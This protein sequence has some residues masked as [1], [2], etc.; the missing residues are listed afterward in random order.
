MCKADKIQVGVDPDDWFA[1]LIRSGDYEI[2]AIPIFKDAKRFSKE[3]AIAF[4]KKYLGDRKDDS[5]SRK[6]IIDTRPYVETLYCER[7][8]DLCV[9]HVLNIII[10]H[11][12]GEALD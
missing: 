5:I 3:E 4:A 2:K 12:Y 11:L 7:A 9:E 10:P 1:K 6:L 8:W